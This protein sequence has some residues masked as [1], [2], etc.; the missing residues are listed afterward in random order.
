MHGN[1]YRISIDQSLNTFRL[2]SVGQLIC[3]IH[4]DFNFTACRFFYQ[5]TEFSSTFCPGTGFCGRAGEVPGLLCPTQIAVIFHII[6]S[7]RSTSRIAGKCSDQICGILISLIFQLFLIPLIDTIYCFL[8]GVDIHIFILCD[9]HAIFFLPASHDLIISGTVDLTFIIY[10]FLS[11]FINNGLLF[12]CQAVV[13]I[14]VDTE[15]QTVIVGIP[16]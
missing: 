4:I 1:L 6:R 10:R 13:D 12:R 11:G 3:C 2:V 9:R 7:G 16:Q 15:E 5:F 14:S 8:E